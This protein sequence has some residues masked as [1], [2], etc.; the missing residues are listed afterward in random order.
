MLSISDEYRPDLKHFKLPGRGPEPLGILRGVIETV[1]ARV[2]GIEASELL[3]PTRGIAAVAFARQVAMY[4]ARVVGRLRFA[5]VGEVF[6]RDRS[7]VAHACRIV[8]NRR[9]NP[10]FDY[11]VEMLEGIVSHIHCLESGRQHWIV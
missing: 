7:T 8:E 11:T 9:D 6:G 4:L 10:A 1:V 5:E 3:A 2:F